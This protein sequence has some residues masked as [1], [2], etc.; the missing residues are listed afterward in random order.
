M[1]S[2][3]VALDAAGSYGKMVPLALWWAV[4]A[5]FLAV[6]VLATV[7]AL[8]L[9]L[10]TFLGIRYRRNSDNR[11]IRELRKMT[12]IGMKVQ[13]LEVIDGVPSDDDY[14]EEAGA[15]DFED[16]VPMDPLLRK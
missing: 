10:A 15:T 11:A 9:G 4:G 14:D 12:G 6:A 13:S 1:D 3:G 8:L 7:T 5:G 16:A 2:V